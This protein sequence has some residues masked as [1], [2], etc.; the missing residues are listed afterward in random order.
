MNPILNEVHAHEELFAFLGVLVWIVLPATALFVTA[1]AYRLKHERMPRTYWWAWLLVQGSSV[2]LPQCVCAIPEERF[3][4][5]LTLLATCTAIVFAV[6]F[7]VS[8]TGVRRKRVVAEETQ[9]NNG[10]CT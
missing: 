3:M 5:W 4:G 9:T 8:R 2:F 7:P 10:L 1:V 6:A